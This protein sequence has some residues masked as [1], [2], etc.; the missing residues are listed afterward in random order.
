MRASAASDRTVSGAARTQAVTQYKYANAARR[1]RI[2]PSP[3]NIASRRSHASR[4]AMR[5]A[6]A[7][8][9]ARP[10]SLAV[11]SRF[12]RAL[13]G[14]VVL[15]FVFGCGGRSGLLSFESNRAPAIQLR[16]P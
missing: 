6:E 3:L 7:G 11:R 9:E 10:A 14:R 16:V 5:G 8:A 4:V 1:V 2:P 12:G 15:A 13:L